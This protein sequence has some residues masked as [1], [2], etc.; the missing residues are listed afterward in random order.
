MEIIRGKHPAFWDAAALTE[1]LSAYDG[2]HLD[3]GT[4]DGRY[5]LHLAR[6]SPSCF[7]IG[8]D[9]SRENLRG[10][11]R[12]SPAN[13]LFVIANALVL[14]PELDEK[15]TAISINFP[16]GSLLEGLL[17]D[18]T[19]VVDGLCRVARPGA[20]MA[21]RLNG[22]A[23]AECGWSLEDG[24]TQARDVLRRGGWQRQRMTRLDSAALRQFPSSWAKRLAYGRDPRSIVLHGRF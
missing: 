21:V 24:A 23:L 17:T 20:E 14:P 7:V 10:T 1:R 15:A 16:W 12:Q 5:T 13:A 22:G 11:S 9:A 3:I 19:R 4:G 2:L 6:R 18:D 8:L